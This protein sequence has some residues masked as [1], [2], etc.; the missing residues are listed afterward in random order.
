MLEMN[1]HERDREE[2]R[3]AYAGVGSRSISRRRSDDYRLLCAGCGRMLAGRR[4][5]PSGMAYD[6]TSRDITR[7]ACSLGAAPAKDHGEIA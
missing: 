3:E 5:A 2:I 7:R 1:G 6:R 4:Q